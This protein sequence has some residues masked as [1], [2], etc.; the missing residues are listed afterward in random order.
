MG[1]C[2]WFVGICVIYGTSIVPWRQDE[3][4]RIFYFLTSSYNSIKCFY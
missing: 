1:A 3:C 4:E 2:Y